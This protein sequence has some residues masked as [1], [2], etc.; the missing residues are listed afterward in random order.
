MLNLFLA[1]N[2]NFKIVKVTYPSSSKQYAYKTTLP[3]VTGD[4]VVVDSPR[5][6]LVVLPVVDVIPGAECSEVLLNRATKW[7]VQRVNT[8]AYKEAQEMER[9]LNKEINRVR[10]TKARKEMLE[11]AREELGQEA[12]DNLTK[13][14]RL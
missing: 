5:D 13:L 11:T 9:K 7:I 4:Q 12:V 8:L 1:Q 6:G 14:V 3:I 10:A 2:E